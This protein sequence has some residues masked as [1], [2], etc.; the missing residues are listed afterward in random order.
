M[1]H[2]GTFAK[3]Y[4]AFLFVAIFISLLMIAFA[5]RNRQDTRAMPFMVLIAGEILWMFFY[6]LHLLE[7][8]H[9]A[10]QPYFWTKLMFLGIVMVPASFLVWTAVF[11][12]HEERVT[13]FAISL[14]SIEPL[15]FN[16][17][18]WTDPWHGWFSGSFKT[19]GQL[20]TAFYL[21]TLY[22]YILLLTGAIMQF[23]H[24]VRAQPNYRMQAFVVMMSMPISTVFNVVSIVLME[25]LKL[26]FSPVGFLVVG[27][28]FSYVQ[29][30]HRLFDILPVARHKVMDEILD[31]VVVLDNED[32]I[33]DMN[34]A[35][36]RMLGTGMKLSQGRLAEKIIPSWNELSRNF[37]EQEN[38]NT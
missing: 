27:I 7:F 30:R 29:W 14:L 18:I 2:A 25:Q 37:A 10:S 12:H 8:I 28:I 1:M 24:F 38:S 16:L 11:T 21:H 13:P 3:V 4:A 9:P 15:V 23:F 35:A 17:V 34:P 32:R 20:G 5:W 6:A 22:S 19:T 33:I 31:G 26:D 36:R